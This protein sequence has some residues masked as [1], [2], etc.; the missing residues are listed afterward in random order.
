MLKIGKI[1]GTHGLKGELKV[2][3]YSDFSDQRFVVGNVIYIDQNPFVIQT[4]RMHK[5]NYLVSFKDMQ[6]I[7]LVEK[8]IGLYVYGLKDDIELDEGEYFY[9]D[10]IGCDVYNYQNYLGKVIKISNNGAHDIL[11]IKTNEKKISIPYVDAFIKNEDID[12]Q[13]IDVEL[14]KGFVDED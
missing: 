7:N 6:D 2:R 4:V 8:Y 3:S 9:E 14:I 1:L 5:G 10:L 13:R 12:N 11:V